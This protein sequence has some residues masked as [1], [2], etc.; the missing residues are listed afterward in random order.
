[1]MA[2]ALKNYIINL[3]IKKLGKP[4][5][6]YTYNKLN[7]ISGWKMRKKYIYNNDTEIFQN[8]PL[9]NGLGT[10]F[11][12]RFI[13]ITVLEILERES[14]KTTVISLEFSGTQIP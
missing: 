4:I 9:N 1:M 3:K 11:A 8:L 13:L 6:M 12:V 10:E 2:Y 14:L 7:V 5:Q